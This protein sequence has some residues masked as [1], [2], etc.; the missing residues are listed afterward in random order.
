MLEPEYCAGKFTVEP[1]SLSL[2]LKEV[3]AE[4]PK[5]AV[6]Y[7]LRWAPKSMRAWA[8]STAAAAAV[9]T[10][11]ATATTAV[12]AAA[13]AHLVPHLLN[14]SAYSGAE[15]VSAFW[16]APAPTLITPDLA[17]DGELTVHAHACSHQPS[18]KDQMTAATVRS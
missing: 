17:E 11:A 2:K 9:T 4:A 6:V 8:R 13:A 14:R 1:L 12:A 7:E 15:D 16:E 10:A 3:P 18:T 5:V